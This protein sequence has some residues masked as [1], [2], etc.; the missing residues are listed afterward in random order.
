MSFAETQSRDST[1]PPP[2]LSLRMSI[3]RVY[4]AIAPAEK[5]PCV[6]MGMMG[7]PRMEVATA[8]CPPSACFPRLLQLAGAP[9]GTWKTVQMEKV[10]RQ[11]RSC[12]SDRDKPSHH[13]EQEERPLGAPRDTSGAC[14]WVQR[15][16]P[17]A[18][19]PS[20]GAMS[21]CQQQQISRNCSEDLKQHL[22][23]QLFR[24]SWPGTLRTQF[25]SRSDQ[26]RKGWLMT[27]GPS[28]P[29]Q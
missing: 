22:Q 20:T 23:P 19:C 4:P 5:V 28:S 12:G 3:S 10:S 21:T 27:S 29:Q 14:L 1:P 6:G 2:S 25:D 7:G 18:L 26:E 16:K 9:V 8:R 11:E 15:E 17:Q 13:G 24:N